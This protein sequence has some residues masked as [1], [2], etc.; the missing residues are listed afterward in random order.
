[1]NVRPLSPDDLNDYRRIRLRALRDHPENFGST[2][3]QESRMT[4]EQWERRLSPSEDRI[5]L[6]LYDG[7][8]LMGT[9]VLVREQ[10]ERM[11]HKANLYAMYV[12]PEARGK[13]AGRLLLEELLK[14]AREMDGLEQI[15]LSVVSGNEP[16]RNLYRQFGF[17][18]YGVE[19]RAE[20]IGD[21]ALDVEWMV[22]FL[23]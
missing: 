10:R 3:E 7:E 4:T 23:T 1:M 18:T 5:S 11:R 8:R 6:G 19:P 9:A 14:R 17:I 2:Y 12:A 22:C 15:H 21:R 16:A 13:G 20:K